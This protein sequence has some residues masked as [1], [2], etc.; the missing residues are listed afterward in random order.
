MGYTSAPSGEGTTR[1]F[2]RAPHQLVRDRDDFSRAEVVGQEMETPAGLAGW[3]LAAAHGRQP[4]LVLAGELG[5]HGAVPALLEAGT[6]LAVPISGASPITANNEK[7]YGKSQLVTTFPSMTF[8]LSQTG[9][10]VQGTRATP[11]MRGV[12]ANRCVQLSSSI[13]YDRSQVVLPWEVQARD[14]TQ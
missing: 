13:Q 8:A 11:K 6:V 7:A 4:C 12:P 14:A 1:I 5:R 10:R 2:E 9:Y 3:R